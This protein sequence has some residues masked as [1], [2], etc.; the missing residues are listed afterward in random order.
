MQPFSQKYFTGADVLFSYSAE[1]C[2]ASGRAAEERTLPAPFIAAKIGPPE[3]EWQQLDNAKLLSFFGNPSKF[4]IRERLGLRIPKLDSLLEETEPLE[5]HGLAKYLLEQDFLNRAL[6]GE[7]FEPLFP[8]ARARGTLPPGRAGESHLRE[9]SANARLFAEVVRQKA[10]N[11]AEPEQLQLTIGRFELS[12]RIDSLFDGCLLRQRLT[13]RKAKDLLGAWI[14]HLMMNCVRPTESI[15]ITTT[16]E[17]HPVIERFAP[18]AEDP[19]ALLAALL[20]FYSRGLAEPLP[21]F[22]RS[23]YTFRRTG[24]QSD[25]RIFSTRKGAEGLG[26]FAAPARRRIRI[27]TGTRRRLFRS[28]FSQCERPARVRVSSD[29]D[30][31]FRARS[32]RHDEGGNVNDFSLLDTEIGSGRLLIEASAGT[33]KTFTIT[34]LVLRLL[35][36]RADLTIDQILVTTFTELATA[37]LRGRIRDLLRDALLAF[38]TG[39][40]EHDL[41]RRVLEKYPDHRA[42]AVRLKD[43]LADF[44]EAPIYTIHG[45]CQRVLADQAF[46]TGTLFDAELVTDERDLFREVTWDFWRRNFYSNDSLGVFLAIQGKITPKKLLKDLEELAKNPTL[47]ILPKDLRSSA[48]AA[49]NVEEALGEVRKAWP[50]CADGIH[51]FFAK[52]VWAKGAYKNA[53]LL[54]RMLEDLEQVAAGEGASARQFNS[55]EL[56]AA[57]VIANKGLRKGSILPENP[58]FGVCQNFVDCSAEFCAGLRAEFHAWAPEE[59]RR[60]KEARNVLAFEDLLIHLD[61]ALRN[62][63]GVALARSIREQYRVALV[64]EFQDTDP[65]QYSI[66]ERIYQASDAT[67]AF[68]GDPKQAIY[69]FRGA[70][71]FTYL[72]AARDTK[73]QFTLRTTGA[74]KADSLGR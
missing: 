43:A 1:N 11:R 36:E 12:A 19:R 22:P 2:L 73:R 44:D 40:S 57:E 5:P 52:P 37:E 28:R 34:G 10:R 71:V 29:R 58:I 47:T 8:V 48:A 72:N 63:G 27:G 3:A 59:L 38:Q 65:V 21:F 70:D 4:L 53:A 62:D 54:A 61:E 33:G 16:S 30:C 67:V 17:K 51:A 50:K 15:L 14:D 39:K 45:F 74:R 9:L 23:S 18:P 60:R 56:L 66:F 31:D 41:L 68:I 35:L 55:I 20:D 6:G 32:S 64:D 7:E 42:A 25:Q 46:E 26:R 49:V 13:T 24:G 69:S